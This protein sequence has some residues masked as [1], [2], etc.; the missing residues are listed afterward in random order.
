MIGE[1]FVGFMSAVWAVWTW[2][3]ETFDLRS[4]A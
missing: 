4:F 1:N 3:P 2:D